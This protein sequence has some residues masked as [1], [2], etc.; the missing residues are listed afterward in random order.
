MANTPTPHPTPAGPAQHHT[1]GRAKEARKQSK[2]ADSELFFRGA[3]EAQAAGNRQQE[4]RPSAGRAAGGATLRWEA[5]RTLLRAECVGVGGR[6][7]SVVVDRTASKTETCPTIF[8]L[9][10][11]HRTRSYILHGEASRRRSA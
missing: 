9:L 4:A 5:A 7:W 2:D 6:R 11:V 8:S 1:H 10:A 3:R